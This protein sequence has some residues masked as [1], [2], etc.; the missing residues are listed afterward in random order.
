MDRV[1]AALADIV[2]ANPD[3]TV[4]VVAH[5]VSLR[6][7][8]ASALGAGP[9]LITRLRLAN[10]SVSTLEQRAGA[11]AV[12]RRANVE[13][14]E[15]DGLESVILGGGRATLEDYIVKTNSSL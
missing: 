9:E 3:G 7:A 10:C 1:A 4:A 11:A 13:L 15:G 6:A 2:A 5:G 12:L 14:T 8:I